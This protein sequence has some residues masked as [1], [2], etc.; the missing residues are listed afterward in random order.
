MIIVNMIFRK[1]KDPIVLKWLQHISKR[2]VNQKI[3]SSRTKYPKD[4]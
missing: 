1:K 3:M 2:R 4:L